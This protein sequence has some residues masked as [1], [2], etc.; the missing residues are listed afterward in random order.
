[1][2]E[3]AQDDLIFEAARQLLH[4]N[5]GLPEPTP[6]DLD[7]NVLLGTVYSCSLQS[8]IGLQPPTR[9]YALPQLAFEG[10]WIYAA[11]AD[12][13]VELAYQFALAVRD[14][15]LASPPAH[16]VVVRVQDYEYKRSK[17]H[18][19]DTAEVEVLYA[20]IRAHPSIR[21]VLADFEVKKELQGRDWIPLSLFL[22]QGAFG[23]NHP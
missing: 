13:D 6:R 17:L 23:R 20:G 7:P 9:R 11:A 5:R 15:S 8:L 4:Y 19:L 16:A 3:D 21:D 22:Q 1:M 10:A 12:G 2:E 18:T 14:A